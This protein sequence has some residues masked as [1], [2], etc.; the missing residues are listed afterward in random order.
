MMLYMSDSGGGG[1]GGN[2][3]NSPSPFSLKK[4]WDLT[5]AV[6]RLQRVGPSVGTWYGWVQRFVCRGPGG[7]GVPYM[8]SSGS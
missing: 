1:G 4:R 7:A 2:K 3:G 6:V 8:E 5:S